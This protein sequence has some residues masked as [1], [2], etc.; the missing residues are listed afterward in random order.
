VAAWKGMQPQITEFKAV[1]TKNNLQE[2]KI[3]PTGLTDS[4]CRFMPEVSRKLK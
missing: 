2:L 1:L 4:S 3:A